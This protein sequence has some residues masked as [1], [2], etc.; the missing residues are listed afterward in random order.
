MLSP[1]CAK[2]LTSALAESAVGEYCAS[3]YSLFDHV[4]GRTL[5]F[6]GRGDKGLYVWRPNPESHLSK[7]V[8]PIGADDWR[9]F[10]CVENGTFKKD[11][12]YVL[13][14]GGRHTLTRMI[15]AR[16]GGRTAA[17]SDSRQKTP[18]LL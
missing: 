13:A 7:S 2:T 1:D 15:D 16:D 12:A 6:S 9:R 18:D 14:P 5:F 3:G 11:D 4:S 8:S 17:G 10:I